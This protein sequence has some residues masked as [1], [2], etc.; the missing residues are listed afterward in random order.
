MVASGTSLPMQHVASLFAA[1]LIVSCAC[2][3]RRYVVDAIDNQPGGLEP[4]SAETHRCG[5]YIC[6]RK[7]E[8]L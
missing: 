4:F 2:H 6:M 7:H 8:E 3:L 5:G 1:K